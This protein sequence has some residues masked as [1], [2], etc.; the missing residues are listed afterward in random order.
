M[1]PG[2]ADDV[3]ATKMIPSHGNNT[4]KMIAVSPFTFL[5]TTTDEAATCPSSP[6]ITK[7]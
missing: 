2:D 4:M 6:F 7:Q 5:D 1:K 3:D